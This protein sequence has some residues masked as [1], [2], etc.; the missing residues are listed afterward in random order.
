MTRANDGPRS[1][2]RLKLSTAFTGPSA[3]A[4]TD[5]SGRLHVPGYLAVS[6][7]ANGEVAIT[8]SLNSSINDEAAR[9]R[10]TKPSIEMELKSITGALRDETQ[11]ASAITILAAAESWV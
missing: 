4:S 11:D 5:P 2:S 8:H 3:T 7:R 6:R 9:H 10:H 1:S